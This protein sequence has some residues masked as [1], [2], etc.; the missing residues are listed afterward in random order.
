MNSSKP[1]EGENPPQRTHQWVKPKYNKK[2]H[3]NGKKRATLEHPDNE[4][5]QTTPLNPTEPLITEVHCMK[6]ALKAEHQQLQKQTK[7]SH[8][9]WHELSN[10][11]N[12][13]LPTTRTKWN[14]GKQT[15]K[16]RIQKNGYK[17]AQ[18]THIQLQVTEWEPQQ[19]EKGNRNY[20]QEP[21]RNEEYTF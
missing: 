12:G 8:L 18:G 11:I 1:A 10:K 3:S 7:K 6:M 5:K 15:I 16:Y 4:I 20:K 21:G 9:K 13:R 19:C 14:G 17:D 2:A